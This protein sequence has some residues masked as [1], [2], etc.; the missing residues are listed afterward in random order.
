MNASKD[1]GNLASR[2]LP[3]QAATG[4]VRGGLWAVLCL[5]LLAAGRFAPAQ[6]TVSDDVP[7]PVIAEGSVL[8]EPGPGGSFDTYAGDQVEG[9]VIG[10]GQW[11]GTGEVVPGEPCEQCPQPGYPACGPGLGLINRLFGPHCP[12]WVVQVDALMLWQ[13]NIQSRPLFR[14]FEGETRL[15]A[16]DAT[17]QM[18]PGPRVGLF[19]NVDQCHTF[20]ANYF[21]VRP[22]DGDDFV[23][24]DPYA[25]SNLSGYNPP[26]PGTGALYT[27]GLFQSAEF[28][29]RRRECCHPITWLAGFRWVELNQELALE[30]DNQ[31]LGTSGIGSRTGNDLFGGQIGMELG[32]WNSGGPVT[33]TGIGKAGVFYNSAFQR[34]SGVFDVDG[35]LVDQP[36]V[37]AEAEETSF[38]GEL[39]INGSVKLSR[40][41]SWRAGYSFFWLS[42]IAVPASQLGRANFFA[43]SATINTS[44]SV[45]LHGATTGLEARW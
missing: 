41:L 27:S 26:P 22:F 10:D 7:T 29:W 11:D 28:N 30:S 3:R 31:S 12:R 43:G 2:R 21:I 17:T 38:V 24:E 32:L 1:Q 42:G 40:W 9:A 19:L 20:E 34:T 45:L 44:G 16:D 23:P 14:T 6:V 36:T 18:S 15:D 4:F 13:G 5:P 37:S 39:G 35:T 25:A 33:F 8:A